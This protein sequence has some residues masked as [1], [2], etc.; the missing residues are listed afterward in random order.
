M[1][2]HFDEISDPEMKGV[3]QKVMQMLDNART[4]ADI[5]FYITSGKRSIEKNKEVGGEEDSSHLKGLAVDLACTNSNNRFRMVYGLFCAGFKRI[6]IASD[7]IHA[8][9]DTT[10]AQEVLFLE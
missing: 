9:I 8:D 2:K 10:K 1:Y 6:G 4:M 3:D 5:P 7:H